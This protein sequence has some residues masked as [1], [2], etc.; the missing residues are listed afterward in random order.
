MKNNGTSR[1]LYHTMQKNLRG[2]PA[3][4]D[5]TVDRS[6]KK[7][8]GHYLY[9]Y[10]QQKY[11]DLY[12]NNGFN[13]FGHQ[14]HAIQQALKNAVSYSLNTGLP[15]K[16]EQQF[17]VQLKKIYPNLTKL[18]LFPSATDALSCVLNAL[19]DAPSPNRDN[20]DNTLQDPN[21]KE[22]KEK[23]GDTPKTLLSINSRLVHQ[24]GDPLE[25]SIRLTADPTHQNIDAVLINPLRT[26][27]MI[28]PLP[29]DTFQALANDFQ[30]K[31]IPVIGEHLYT[32]LD[33]L[34]PPSIFSLGDIHLFSPQLFSGLPLW[35]AGL[36]A[37]KR[38]KA[39]DNAYANR[40]YS[41]FSVP[42]HQL[43]AG[44][45]TLKEWNRFKQKDKRYLWIRQLKNQLPKEMML[46][47]YGGFFYFSFIWDLSES[48]NPWTDYLQQVEQRYRQWRAH[49]LD[50]G[51]YLPPRY[52]IP[53]SLSLG[54]GEHELNWAVKNFNL[55]FK[56]A[57]DSRVP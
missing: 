50:H 44:V 26:Y 34:T 1:Y 10:D 27:P 13:L 23:N 57:M 14:H 32:S 39:M 30:K 43:A 16:F 51:I 22:R 28:K 8:R 56:A 24:T 20:K 35:G 6:F 25:N 15:S 31:G 54:V 2:F 33:T 36:F 17:S 46:S 52:D 48:L 7:G 21:T 9:D 47:Y 53:A 41:F 4:A 49:C 18:Y 42:A 38:E 12:F 3:L 29:W 37:S 55:A 45:A 19:L 40:K 5:Q 11:L